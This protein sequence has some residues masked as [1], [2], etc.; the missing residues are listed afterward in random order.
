M[1]EAETAQKRRRTRRSERGSI[2]S[3]GGTKIVGCADD[4]ESVSMRA[5]RADVTALCS[6]RKTNL[7]GKRKNYTQNKETGQRTRINYEEVQCVM[8]LW[9]S[10]KTEVL[11][12]SGFAISAAD[13]EEVFSRRV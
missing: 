9:L 4:G 7:G 6:V 12:S 5:Q 13:S 1:M 10:S 2:E 3:Y 8:Y 11:T